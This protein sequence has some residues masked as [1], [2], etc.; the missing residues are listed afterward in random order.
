MT[1]LSWVDQETTLLNGGNGNDGITTGAGTDAVDGGAG[2]D[3][4][5]VVGNLTATD[6]FEGGDGDDTISLSDASLTV[7]NGLT[8]SEANTFNAGFNNVEKLTISDELSQ[9]S[10][11]IGY[12]D[13]INHVT[14]ASTIN[15]VETLNGFDSGDT[16]E[17]TTTDTD[18][19]TV[20]VTAQL[21]EHQMY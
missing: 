14:L 2:N 20:G 16:I 18:V 7:L 9:A 21:Q 8:V 3:T 11:D 6:T 1:I 4:F 10:F 5:T 12:L 19:L 17:L 13:S 15:G